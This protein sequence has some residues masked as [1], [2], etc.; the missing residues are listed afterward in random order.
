M[1]SFV[2]KLWNPSSFQISKMEA[3]LGKWKMDYDACEGYDEFMT[4]EVNKIVIKC[5][6]K[7]HEFKSVFVPKINEYIN[8]F[9]RSSTSKKYFFFLD[10]S[11][12]SVGLELMVLWKGRKAPW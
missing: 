4:A 3:F 9:K 7:L 11:I 10:P 12:F 6:V 1:D 5:K 2:W 8:E